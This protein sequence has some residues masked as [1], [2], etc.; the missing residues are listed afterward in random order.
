MEDDAEGWCRFATGRLACDGV[1]VGDD[2]EFAVNVVCIE[3][4]TTRF[5]TWEKGTLTVA[6]VQTQ[7][8]HRT[9][10]RN[11]RRFIPVMQPMQESA[12]DP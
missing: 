7:S 4:A 1:V 3:L 10:S 2:G 9:S 6:P 8:H 12:K 11:P 5:R